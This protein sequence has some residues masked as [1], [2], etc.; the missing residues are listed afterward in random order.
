MAACRLHYAIAQTLGKDQPEPYHLTTMSD[1]SSD[2]YS[3]FDLSEFTEEDFAQIDAAI[4]SQIQG[5]DAIANSSFQSEID[6]LDLSSLTPEELAQL[7]SAISLKLNEHI[8]GP[9]IQVELE[10]GEMTPQVIRPSPLEQFRSRRIFS[11]TDLVSPAWYVYLTELHNGTYK[12]EI[13]RCEVQFD[14]GLRGKRSRP[15]G[16]RPNSFVSSSGKKISIEKSIAEKNDVITKQGRVRR[17]FIF[18]SLEI[19]NDHNTIGSS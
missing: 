5:D 14:Y 19:F 17:G 3:A 16:K 4:S 7:D 15:I 12:T 9:S 2:S 6:G 10:D 18:L 8:G 1:I 13:Y 11:V